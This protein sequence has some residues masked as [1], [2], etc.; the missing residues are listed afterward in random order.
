MCGA[1]SQYVARCVERSG[2][3]LASE[4]EAEALMWERE[5]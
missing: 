5:R 1:E 3:M 4:T 2:S